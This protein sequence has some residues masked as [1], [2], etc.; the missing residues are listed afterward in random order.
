MM[1]AILLEMLREIPKQMAQAAPVVWEFVKANPL[2]TTIVV[3]ALMIGGP[4][5]ARTTFARGR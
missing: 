3:G 5:H 1:D 2:L 4:T